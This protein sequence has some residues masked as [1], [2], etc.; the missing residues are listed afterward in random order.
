MDKLLVLFAQFC[1][2]GTCLHYG[3]R[4]KVV[5]HFKRKKKLAWESGGP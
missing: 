3:L 5:F 2:W 1:S 4:L